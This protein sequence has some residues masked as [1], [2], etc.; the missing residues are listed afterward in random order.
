MDVNFKAKIET[1]E[2]VI[3]Q[4]KLWAKQPLFSSSSAKLIKGIKEVKEV[5]HEDQ[6]NQEDPHHTWQK[7]QGKANA[8]LANIA[9]KEKYQK[10]K[11]KY[12]RRFFESI[13]QDTFGKYAED[14]QQDIEKS[15]SQEH[16][17]KLAKTFL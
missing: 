9:G 14:L 13:S 7:I 11:H 16:Q 3:A 15:Q 10:D 17:Q 6:K 5:I 8:T 1:V 4:D 12:A 2:N